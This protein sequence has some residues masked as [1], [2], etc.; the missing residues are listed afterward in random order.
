MR[1][2]LMMILLLI[3]GGCGSDDQATSPD[4][5]IPPSGEQWQFQ[6]PSTGEVD[7]VEWEIKFTDT[8]DGDTAD[9]FV[10]VDIGRP[11]YKVRARAVT[12]GGY[13]GDWVVPMLVHD[14]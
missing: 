8:L 13:R 5:P 11:G 1:T 9:V 2:I 12:V 6:L 10:N 4:C 3:F 7:K 14:E